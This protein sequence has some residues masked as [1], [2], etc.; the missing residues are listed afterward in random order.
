MAEVEAATP[1]SPDERD[2]LFNPLEG[3]RLALCVSGGPDS[4]ALLHLIAEWAAAP[5]IADKYRS[6][7]GTDHIGAANPIVVVSVDHGL[8][9]EAERETAFVAEQSARLGLPCWRLSA[10]G[11]AEA[12]APVTGIQEWARALRH[13]LILEAIEDEE[14]RSAAGSSADGPPTGQASGVRRLLVMAHH[15]DDQAETVLMRLGRGSGID[16]LS[17]M[18]ARQPIEVAIRE[19]TALRGEIYRPFLETAKHRLLSSLRARRA[20][21][22]DD[23]SNVDPRFERVRIRK[24]LAELG[25]LGISAEGIALSARRLGDAQSLLAHANR[26]LVA[27]SVTW[28]DGLFGEVA[29]S[30]PTIGASR[31]ALIRVLETMLRAFGGQSRSAGLSQIEELAEDVRLAALEGGSISGRTLGGC[32]LD[33][34]SVGGGRLRVFREFGRDGLPEVELLPGTA[35]EWDGGRFSLAATA[36]APWAVTVGALRA[37]GWAGLKR[38]MPDLG[39]LGLPAGPMATMPALRVNGEIVDVP[40]LSALI[41]LVGGFGS[42]ARGTALTAWKSLLPAAGA[43]FSARFVDVFTE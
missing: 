21:W 17:G 3:R 41:Q 37:D 42:D 14:R 32:R 11:D 25:E 19:G 1:I 12:V 6:I 40:F 5:R 31:H 18:R 16:G 35:V 9:S 2:K 33:V 24:A 22:I 4:M 10:R 20:D 26:Q 38:D 43:Y 27:Q 28:N 13:R 23:P 34:S 15:L 29:L 7:A 39:K 8:R 36:E 30:G